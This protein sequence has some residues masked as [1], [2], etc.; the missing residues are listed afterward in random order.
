VSHPASATLLVDMAHPDVT[1]SL[2]GPWADLAE[3]VIGKAAKGLIADLADAAVAP[4]E[5]GREAGDGIP[6]EIAWLDRQVVV[7]LELTEDDRN[8]LAGLGWVVVPPDVTAVRDA[9]NSAGDR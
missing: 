5:V 6:L 4:P 7:D 8:D 1:V 3:Q 9:L 2:S